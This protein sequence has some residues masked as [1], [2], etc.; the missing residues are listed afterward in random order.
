MEQNFGH[1][2]AVTLFSAE[3]LELPAQARDCPREQ[4]GSQTPALTEDLHS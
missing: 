1:G 3:Q 4:R 2:M